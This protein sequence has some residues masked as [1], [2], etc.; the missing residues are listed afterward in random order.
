MS[1]SGFS[2]TVKEVRYKEKSLKNDPKQIHKSLENNLEK[3][4]KKKKS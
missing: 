3:D 1:R 2:E 4:S